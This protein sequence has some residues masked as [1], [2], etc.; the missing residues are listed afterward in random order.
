MGVGDVAP[1]APKK[2][3]GKFFLGKYRYHV[4]F[5]HFVNFSYTDFRAIMSCPQKLT[6]L[7]RLSYAED[8][9]K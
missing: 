1:P 5:G 3:S 4:K 7:L 9:L 6:E 8:V 2:N